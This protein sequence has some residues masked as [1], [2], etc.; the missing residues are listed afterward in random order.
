MIKVAVVYVV[1]GLGAAE[2]ADVFLGNLAPQW[3]LNAALVLLLIGFPIALLLAWAYN[4]TSSGVVRDDETATEAEVSTARPPVGVHDR[5]RRSIAVLPFVNRSD[6]PANEY[7]A[8]GITD[9]ILT[10]LTLVEG[11]RVI[12]RT[13]AMH[14]KGTTKNTRAIA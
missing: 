7:F 9:D 13:S 11:L 5:G 2:A 4:I 12:S 3:A 6:D 8:D 1:V 14:Y 10:S